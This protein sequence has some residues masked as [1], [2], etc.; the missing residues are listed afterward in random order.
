[1]AGGTRHSHRGTRAL[2]KPQPTAFPNQLR[3]VGLLGILPSPKVGA[4]AVGWG[5]LTGGGRVRAPP[6]GL[7]PVQTSPSFKAELT[8]PT[9][10]LSSPCGEGLRLLQDISHL[11]PPACGQPRGP[12]STSSP[13]PVPSTL[14]STYSFSVE[15]TQGL[16]FPPTSVHG[17]LLTLQESAPGCVLTSNA[18][19]A[20]CPTVSSTGWPSGALKKRVR[21]PGTASPLTP[22]AERFCT[23]CSDP[24]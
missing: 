7:R 21:T 12:I 13:P 10:L 14:K 3:A 16:R 17:A 5:V 8:L 11:G 15:L 23:W 6:G 18:R 22:S 4:P 2:E 24:V 9:A 20:A 19:W 1:M